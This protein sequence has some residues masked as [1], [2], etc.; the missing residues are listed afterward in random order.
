MS[1]K[2]DLEG[3]KAAKL[4]WADVARAAEQILTE[5]GA[6]ASMRSP[7]MADIARQ[8][9]YSAAMLMRQIRLKTWLEA[10]AVEL[11]VDPERYLA[12]GFAGL[13]AAMALDRHAPD[14]TRELLDRVA[15]GAVT[16]ESLRDEVQSRVAKKRL[17]DSGD[18]DALAAARYDRRRRVKRAIEK[19]GHGGG[20][21]DLLT[22]HP[23]WRRADGTVAEHGPVCR[24]TWWRPTQFG[25]EGFDLLHVP[26]GTTA[27][28]IDDRIARA[29]V[30]AT[31]FSTYR[32]VVVMP[33]PFLPRIHEALDWAGLP[34]LGILTAT[35]GPPGSDWVDIQSERS[36]EPAPMTERVRRFEHAVSEN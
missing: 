9:G 1:E 18:R 3:A 7:V 19:G 31:F 26:A 30:S 23:A 34:N 17:K 12:A 28:A 32:L 5:S 14:E 4:A 21:G 13:E 11:G 36:A 33:T 35:L 22:P 6:L 29:L 10:K 25:P 24:A 27:R 20:Q 15:E 16:V 8:S 2:A